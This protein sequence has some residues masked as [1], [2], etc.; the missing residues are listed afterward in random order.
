MCMIFL[1]L[2]VSCFLIIVHFKGVI[3]GA[4]DILPIVD[5]DLKRNATRIVEQAKELC[6]MKS[7]IYLI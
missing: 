6:M 5:A 4:A 2:F 1:S 3:V 7:V